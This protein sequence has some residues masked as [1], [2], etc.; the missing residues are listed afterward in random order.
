M[1]HFTFYATK[2]PI[3]RQN[4]QFEKQTSNL[5]NSWRNAVG[6]TTILQGPNNDITIETGIFKTSCGEKKIALSCQEFKMTF[7]HKFSTDFTFWRM[8]S[9]NFMYLGT[10]FRSSSLTRRRES[11]NE[12]LINDFDPVVVAITPS[13]ND[14]SSFVARHRTTFEPAKLELKIA[15][16][17]RLGR[18]THKTF[19]KMS[20]R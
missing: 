3:S 7:S 8:K 14:E 2:L 18:A 19:T 11:L 10:R 15:A 9:Y 13:L 16:R 20:T 1:A 12:G 17:H 5:I 6:D 4:S